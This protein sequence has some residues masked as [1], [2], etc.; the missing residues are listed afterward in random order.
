M[1]GHIALNVTCVPLEVISE[2]ERREGAELAPVPAAFTLSKAGLIQKAGQW[3]L[4]KQ[5]IPLKAD[6]FWGAWVAEVAG[7]SMAKSAMLHTMKD[8][9]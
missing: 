4:S 3:G 6:G 5:N 8:F 1:G 7:I 2:E 9:T